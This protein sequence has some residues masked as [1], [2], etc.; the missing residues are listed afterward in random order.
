[1]RKLSVLTELHEQFE[2]LRRRRQVSETDFANATWSHYTFELRTDELERALPIDLKAPG[3]SQSR[4]HQLR[5]LREHLGRVETV[6]VQW[7]ADAFIQ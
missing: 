6:L 2:T 5:A 3:S 7:A 1:M 4:R